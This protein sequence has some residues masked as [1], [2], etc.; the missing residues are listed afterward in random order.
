M[1]DLELE[2]L[3]APDLYLTRPLDPGPGGL[4]LSEV[5][6]PVRVHRCGRCNNQTGIFNPACPNRWS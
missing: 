2:E 5:D 3:T 6:E 1:D 4:F